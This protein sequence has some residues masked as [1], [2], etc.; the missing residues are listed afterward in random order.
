MEVEIRIKKAKSLMGAAKTFFNI[1]D[2]SRKIKCQIY[3][4]GPLTP[5]YGAAK[6]GT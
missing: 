5:Y 2:V 6:L 4:A 3:T 1:K